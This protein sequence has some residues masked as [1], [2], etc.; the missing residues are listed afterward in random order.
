MKK[1]SEMNMFHPR[2]ICIFC[3]IKFQKNVSGKKS[4]FNFFHSARKMDTTKHFQAMQQ[5]K[6]SKRIKVFFLSLSRFCSMIVTCE[7]K[8]T[9]NFV[10]IFLLY[11]FRKNMYLCWML[12]QLVITSS[13]GK[14]RKSITQ[15]YTFE[16]KKKERIFLA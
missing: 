13:T 14:K 8:V 11:V 4:M 5:R 3:L 16:S 6:K 7:K 1:D 12:Q 9:K 2:K 15:E 10:W